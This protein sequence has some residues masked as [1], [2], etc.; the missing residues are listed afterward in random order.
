MD[1][2]NQEKK[3]TLS[4]QMSLFDF[5][6]PEEQKELEVKMPDVGEYEKEEILGL[7]KEVLGVYISG[8]PRK[9]MWQH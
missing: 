6:S 8:H 9:N 1:G 2:V 5:A 4:G 7:E 3:G